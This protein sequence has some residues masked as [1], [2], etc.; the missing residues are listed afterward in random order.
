M[1]LNRLI[2]FP[3]LILMFAALPMGFWL[4]VSEVGGAGSVILFCFEMFTYL[5]L[6]FFMTLKKYL[7][8]RTATLY[9]KVGSSGKMKIG[10][11]WTYFKQAFKSIFKDPRLIFAT[12]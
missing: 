11:K 8:F 2:T 4:E 12:N 10:I 1:T 6:G 7:D 5:Y 9:W 3:Y